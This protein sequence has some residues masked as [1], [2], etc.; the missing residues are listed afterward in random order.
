MSTNQSLMFVAAWF[1]FGMTRMVFTLSMVEHRIDHP[2]PIKA[3]AFTPQ[4]ARE[5]INAT[6]YNARGK[7]LLPWYR[8]VSTT[9]W[10]LVAGACWSAAHF[11]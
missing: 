6:N 2:D 3:I 10:I 7:R 11:G 4:A 1:L 8:A 5:R 9:Y